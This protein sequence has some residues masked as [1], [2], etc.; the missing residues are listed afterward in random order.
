VPHGSLEGEACGLFNCQLVH[1]HDPSI[2]ATLGQ[3][4]LVVSPATTGI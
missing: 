1:G 4:R 2:F 3:E